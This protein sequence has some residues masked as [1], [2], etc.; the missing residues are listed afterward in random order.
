MFLIIERGVEETWKREEETGNGKWITKIVTGQT[1]IAQLLF[2]FF[3]Y[4]RIHIYLRSV[5]LS[6]SKVSSGENSTVGALQERNRQIFS[7]WW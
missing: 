6:G 7:I 1:Y 4:S 5:F 3:I 2:C